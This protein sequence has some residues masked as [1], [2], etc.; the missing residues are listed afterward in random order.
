MS[1][2]SKL[3]MK[4]AIT[5]KAELMVTRFAYE[6]S[7]LAGGY[8]DGQVRIFNLNTDNKISQIDTNPSK[9]DYAC[10]CFKDET[11]QRGFH[12]LTQFY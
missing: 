8:S 10:K 4:S 6:D 1:L 5:E 7:L 2:K 9:R 11:H 3:V 12:L